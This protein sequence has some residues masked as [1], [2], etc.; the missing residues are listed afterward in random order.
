MTQQPFA[1][2]PE[3]T[4]GP[5]VRRVVTGNNADGKSYFVSDELVSRGVLRGTALNDPQGGGRDA[6]SR[7]LPSTAPHIEPPRG[8]STTVLISMQPWKELEPRLVRGEIPGL[9]AGGFHR[10]MTV[11][12]LYVAKG[13]LELLVDEGSVILHAGDVIIQRNARHSWRNH[14]DEPVEFIATMI[15]IPE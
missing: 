1:E 2:R 7:L 15:P 5:P 8:G 10:T 12:Y 14:T 9:D 4:A 11:D 13:E 3:M 6:P